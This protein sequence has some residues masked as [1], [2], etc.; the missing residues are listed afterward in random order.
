MKRKKKSYFK[1][2]ILP[3]LGSFI[4]QSIAGIGRLLGRILEKIAPPIIVMGLLLGGIVYVLEHKLN[5]KLLDSFLGRSGNKLDVAAGQV[6]RA[7]Y[8]CRD[9]TLYLQEEGK[10]PIQHTGVKGASLVKFK[11]DSIK[12]DVDNKGFSIEPGLVLGAAD[13]MRMGLD[14]EFIYWRRYG[15]LAGIT[16]PVHRRTFNELQGHVGV[17]YDL[18]NRYFSHT[19]LWGGMSFDKIPMFG[20]R[21]KVGGGI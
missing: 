14:I 18:P 15:L 7:D 6:A 11:N 1:D 5:K 19:S 12:V 17:S 3:L 20:F 10:D 13:S 21:T 8:D 9:Y 2:R 4:T 16:V